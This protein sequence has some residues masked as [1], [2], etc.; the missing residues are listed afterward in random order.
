MPDIIVMFFL[1]GLVA[2]TLRSDLSIP[3]EAYD[4]LSLLL[5]LTIGLKGGMALYGNL[6]PDLLLEMVAVA[7][8][9]FIL[10]LMMIPLLRYAVGLS[11]ADTASF[12]A[13]YG[14]VSA[15]TFAVALAWVEARGLAAGG[16]V[17]LYLV[18]LELPAILTGLWFYRRF[19][20]RTETTEGGA[21][22]WQETLTNRSVVLL[23]G[24]VIIGAMYGPDQ[25]TGVT[26]TLTGAFSVVLSLFLLEMGLVAAETL[27]NLK[28]HHWRVVLFALAMP[29]VLSIP[30]LLVGTL[31]GLET[32]SIVI[33]AALTASAS[34]IAAPVAVRH[35]IPDANIGLAMLASLGVTFPFNVLVGI[36]LYH[37]MLTWTVSP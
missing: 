6:S 12:A 20:K 31:L 34:Y 36:G 32:G 9:G 8:L 26:L 18:L 3:R 29:T 28:W 23:V 25:G 15:G 5:M 37:G 16:Q 11:I 10:P 27:R 33:L 24:G 21:P 13:H 17:T 35:A 4:I 19:G 2:G 30:G 14:S 22:L 1:L 7:A